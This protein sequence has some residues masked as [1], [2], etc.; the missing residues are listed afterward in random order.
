MYDLNI[1]AVIGRGGQTC[2]KQESVLNLLVAI[3]N[4][5]HYSKP[6]W[7]SRTV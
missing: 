3:R 2:E 7:C 4:M 6:F 5:L 1:A